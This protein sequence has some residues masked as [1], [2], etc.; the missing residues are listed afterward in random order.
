MAIAPPVVAPPVDAEVPVD[1]DAHTPP[2]IRHCGDYN[3]ES[4]NAKMGPG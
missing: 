1:T 4:G 2:R 3:A